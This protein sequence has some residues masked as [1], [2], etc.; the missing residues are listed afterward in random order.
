M[1]R[2][3]ERPFIDIRFFDDGFKVLDDQNGVLV[4]WEN[5]GWVWCGR[6]TPHYA[7]KMDSLG[8]VI[9]RCQL[10]HSISA[11]PTGMSAEARNRCQ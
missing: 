8:T 11:T 4:G 10:L 9:F 3:P 7:F 2:C 5:R 1:E 6:G